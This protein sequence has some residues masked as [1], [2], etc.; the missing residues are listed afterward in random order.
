MTTRNAGRVLGID[1]GTRRVGVAVSDPLRVIAQG[2]GTLR[3]DATL[4]QRLCR[5][6]DEKEAS[7]VVVGM[8]YDMNGARGS[9][10]REVDGFIGR[11]RGATRVAIETWDESRTSE[12]AKD[13]F[14]AA[15]MKRKKRRQK[16]RVDEM[17]A[18]IMLQEFLDNLGHAGRGR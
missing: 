1:Y 4:I 2:G 12:D 16:E 9:M 8:P 6:I 3:N 7:L 10:A 14:R 17:A 11:L 13:V 18:R 5:L 15:G